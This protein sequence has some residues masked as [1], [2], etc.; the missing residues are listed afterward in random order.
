MCSISSKIILK[1]NNKT[2]N[3]APNWR[4][5]KCLIIPILHETP[6]HP[7]TIIPSPFLLC[8]NSQTTCRAGH[9][10]SCCLSN[11]ALSC[12]QLQ[13]Q[14]IPN[15]SLFIVSSVISEDTREVNLCMVCL[16]SMKAWQLLQ[17]NTIS[18][19]STPK[20]PCHF[21]SSS[22]CGIITRGD[23]EIKF[24]LTIQCC[25]QIKERCKSRVQLVYKESILQKFPR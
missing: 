10:I 20:I 7:E 9:W 19:A 1:I 15:P 11:S 2:Q 18:S 4:P 24:I 16:G 25:A 14:K 21:W 22:G 12:I 13:L 23:L 8:E 3:H 17:T 5:Q 6:V